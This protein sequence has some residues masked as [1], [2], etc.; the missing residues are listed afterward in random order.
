[1]SQNNRTSSKDRRVYLPASIPFLLL[2]LLVWLYG[3]RVPFWDQWDAVAFYEKVFTGRL[4][5][6]DFWAQHNEHRPFFPRFLMAASALLTS[7]DHR[8]DLAVNMLLGAGAFFCV[9]SLLRRIRACMQPGDRPLL[10]VF[11]S[12]CAFSIR[13][14]ENWVWGIQMHCYLANLLSLAGLAVLAPPAFSQP[15]LL[16]ALLLGV[17]ATFSFATGFGFWPAAFFLLCFREYRSAGERVGALAA[18]FGTGVL[19]AVFYLQ[20]FHTPAHH[21]S[22]WAFVSEPFS[23]LLYFCVILG[24]IGNF[25]YAALLGAGGILLTVLVFVRVRFCGLTKAQAS[26]FFSCMVFSIACALLTLAGRAGYGSAQAF[27]S[28]YVTYMYPFWIGLFALCLMSLRS[29]GKDGGGRFLKTVFTGGLAVM[30]L[31]AV[32][33]SG[34]SVFAMREFSRERMAALPELL[35]PQDD[36][37]LSRLYPDPAKIRRELSRLRRLGISVFREGTEEQF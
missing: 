15:R 25:T 13:Q 4:T 27:S 8:A 35:N 32:L 14:Y 36:E 12:I 30:F 2:V 24:G 18:C 1:M 11:A 33:G 34:A 23:A 28:R 26:L 6:Q 20:G 31:A 37:L 22:V 10:L 9:V 19:C 5:L 7:W 16:L 17:M 29:C 21:P 3:L